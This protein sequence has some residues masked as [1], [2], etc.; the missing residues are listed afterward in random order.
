[1]AGEKSSVNSRFKAL[2]E[3]SQ[4]IWR[5]IRGDEQI[6]KLLKEDIVPGF[7]SLIRNAVEVSCELISKLELRRDGIYD[8]PI[9]P[10][11]TTW[12]ICISANFPLIRRFESNQPC[13]R[14]EAQ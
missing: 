13:Q 5:D 10:S 3:E 7:N 4:S 6:N 12:T 2:G 1:M 14:R 9:N 11:V 8:S